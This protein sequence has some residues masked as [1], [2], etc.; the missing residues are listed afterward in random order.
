MLF[1]VG[2]LRGLRDS[3]LEMNNST[4][5]SLFSS[6]LPISILACDCL[7]VNLIA[8]ESRLTIA[9]RNVEWSP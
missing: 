4:I 3:L 5:S 9:T 7:R 1:I 2:C 6:A 8:L